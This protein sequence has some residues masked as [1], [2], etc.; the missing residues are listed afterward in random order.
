MNVVD[1]SAWLEYF[2]G[3][4]NAAFFSPAIEDQK[5][6]LVP[7]VCLYE[8]FKYI[9]RQVGKREA[10]ETSAAMRQGIVVDLS[11]ALAVRAASISLTHELAMADSIV[12]ATARE[13]DAVV[14]T[15]D[16]DFETLPSV[17]FRPGR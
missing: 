11:A 8:V 3:G 13:H 7:S 16:S 14:W 9:L 17:R 10:L 6:L 2:V 15:Q 4:P 1:S 12:L 5:G